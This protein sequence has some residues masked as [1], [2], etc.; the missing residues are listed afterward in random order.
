MTFREID[1]CAK[2]Q[3]IEIERDYHVLSHKLFYD[4]C[5]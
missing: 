2:H 3:T 1:L 4:M 5:L